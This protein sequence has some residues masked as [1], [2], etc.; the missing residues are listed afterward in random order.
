VPADRSQPHDERDGL[1]HRSDVGLPQRQR[2][3]PVR[4]RER[5][6]VAARPAGTRTWSASGT[7]APRTR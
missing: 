1:H 2:A 4:E 7:C 5:G 6:G 3:H